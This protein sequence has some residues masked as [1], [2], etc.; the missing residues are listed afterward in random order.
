M[1]EVSDASKLIVVFLMLILFVSLFAFTFTT[2][3]TTGFIRENTYDVDGYRAAGYYVERHNSSQT[4]F[5]N[6]T[7]IA[8]TNIF[9]VNTSNIKNIT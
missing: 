3:E 2:P 8:N 5:I 9:Y 7:H 6:V 1:R 4:G